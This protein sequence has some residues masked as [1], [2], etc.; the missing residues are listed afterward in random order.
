MR[1]YTWCLVAPWLVLSGDEAQKPVPMRDVAIRGEAS[2]AVRQ[3][4]VVLEA[5]IGTPIGKV[6]INGH[7]RL[8]YDC[9]SAFSGT[10]SYNPI[11]RLFA[12]IKGVDLITVVKGAVEV[13]EGESCPAMDVRMIRGRAQVDTTQLSGLI[14]FDGDSLPFRGPAWM[15]GDT[16]YHAKLAASLRGKAVHMTVSM[17][18]R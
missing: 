12:K 2:G 4:K 17:F 10:I 5:R 8:E 11:V 14:L 3:V 18:E 13:E 6:P 7:L 16:S 15:V 9:E 1:L